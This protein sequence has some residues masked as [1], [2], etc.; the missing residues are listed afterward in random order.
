M[1]SLSAL[2]EHVDFLYDIGT[3]TKSQFQVLLSSAVHES[4]VHR[5]MNK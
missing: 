2:H 4:L 3:R 1:S 5:V